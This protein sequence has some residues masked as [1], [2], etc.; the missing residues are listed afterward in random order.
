M[1]LL[2]SAEDAGKKSENN[3]NSL[4]YSEKKS[5]EKATANTEWWKFNKKKKKSTMCTQIWR[6]PVHITGS[7]NRH[8]TDLA[9]LCF[10]D[11]FEKQN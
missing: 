6:H 4:L 8:C 9:S 2:V 7:E 10:T 3:T 1:N 5:R 11:S